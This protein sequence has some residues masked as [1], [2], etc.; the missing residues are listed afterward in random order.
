MPV[1]AMFYIVPITGSPSVSHIVAK[2]VKTVEERGH[3]YV[4]TPA[5]TVFEAESIEDAFKTIAMAIEA[6]KSFS[7]VKRV[8]AEIKIDERLDKPLSL[9][10]MVK[11][12]VEK[13]DRG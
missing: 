7:E 1:I 11:S 8:I 13:K 9:D 3:K 5:A 2:A 4:I 12:V 6:V 10:A